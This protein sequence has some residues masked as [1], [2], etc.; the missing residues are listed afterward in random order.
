MKRSLLL[1]LALG[2]AFNSAAIAQVAPGNDPAQATQR[3]PARV[4]T[5]PW[6]GMKKLLV[7]A[8]VQNG[9]HH[10]SISHAMATIAQMGRDTGKWVTIIKTDSQLLTKEPIVG[11]G[12]RY[13][14]RNI[15]AKNLDF[16]DA[17]FFLGSGSG[18]LSDQQ[19]ADLLTFV[20]DDGKG[21]L[22]GHAAGVA[23][24]DWPEFGELIGAPMDG[25]YS[26]G[27]MS[28]MRMSSTFPG[29]TA[30]PAEFTYHDQ[31]PRTPPTFSS[32]NVNVLFALDPTKMTEEQLALRP[33][34]DFPIIWYDNYGQGRVFNLG[35]GHREEVWDDPKFRTMIT[36]GIEWAL[37]LVDAEG[38]PIERRGP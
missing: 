9:Y 24:F 30:F 20:R 13:E 26:T 32:S 11:T 23:F 1:G 10:D 12:E 29:V 18:T 15:N 5:D 31:F 4:P 8:D 16:F 17:V 3:A 21:F 28:V 6:P 25:E 34:G 7:V 38:R 2:L 36:G 37:G 33:D 27:V 14:G 22:A 19:K 35:V